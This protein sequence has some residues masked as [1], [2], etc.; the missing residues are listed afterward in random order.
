MLWIAHAHVTGLLRYAASDRVLSCYEDRTHVLAGGV[1]APDRQ[2][3]QRNLTTA[4]GNQ[5]GEGCR[6]V[7]T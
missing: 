4:G 5:S 6:G 1:L 7:T 3:P 2:L